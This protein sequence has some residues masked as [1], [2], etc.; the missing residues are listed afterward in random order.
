VAARRR[1]ALTERPSVD[2]PGIPGRSERDDHADYTALQASRLTGCSESQLEY[3]ERRGLVVPSR[4]PNPV[5]RGAPRSASARRYSFRELVALR[6]VRTLLDAGLPLL[7]VRRVVEELLRCGDD[8]AGVRIVTDGDHVWACHD[9]G[10]IADALGRGQLV[11]FIA[12]DLIA[13]EVETVVASFLAERQGFVDE[14]RLRD[15]PAGS[16]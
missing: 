14:L 13:A 8:I 1:H 16:V 10:Q 9:D 3:W 4:V 15:H 6:M 12:V 11:L 5:E 7:R 2:E